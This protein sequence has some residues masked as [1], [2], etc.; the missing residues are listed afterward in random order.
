MLWEVEAGAIVMTEALRSVGIYAVIPDIGLYVAEP[1]S[2]VVLDQRLAYR[3]VSGA[4]DVVPPANAG[5][6][7]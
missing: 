3:S 4:P 2:G 1:L 7:I 5:L 6:P